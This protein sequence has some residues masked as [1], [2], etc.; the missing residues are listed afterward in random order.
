MT[1]KRSTPPNNEELG[2][3][4]VK[5]SPIHQDNTN[6]AFSPRS[7]SASSDADIDGCA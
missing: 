6:L 7:G 4:I 3:G 1:Q 2:P 5:Y